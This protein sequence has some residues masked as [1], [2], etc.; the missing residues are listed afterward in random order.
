MKIQP[1]RSV[2]LALLS[3]ACA[4]ALSACETYDANGNPVYGPGSPV[5]GAPISEFDRYDTNRDGYLSRAEA[6]S[7]S[8][9]PMGPAPRI[10][11]GRFVGIIGNYEA[12][13]QVLSSGFKSCLNVFWLQRQT[14]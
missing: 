5:A 13:P 9:Q 10:G 7:L 2:R 8:L 14:P 4:A 6:A 1:A 12:S 3:I 11:R